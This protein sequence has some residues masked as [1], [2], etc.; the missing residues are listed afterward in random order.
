MVPEFD[1]VAFDLEVGGVSDV[2]ETPFGYHLI[3]RTA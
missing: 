2:F 3:H 1:A